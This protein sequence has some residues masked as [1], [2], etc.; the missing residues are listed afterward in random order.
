MSQFSDYGLHPKTVSAIEKLGF[1]TPS[2]IQEQAIPLIQSGQDISGLAQTGTG[3]TAAYLIPT[4]QR[5]YKTRETEGH[6]EQSADVKPFE[7]WTARNQVLI[8]VPTRELVEQVAQNLRELAPENDFS[9]AAIYGGVAYDGQKKSLKDGADFVIATPGRL[10]D[11]YKDKFF[12]PTQVRSVI[13]DEADRM[14]DMGFKDDMKFLL[15]RIPRDRQFLVL[16]ATLNFDVLTVAYEYGSD[17]VEIEIDKSLPKTEQVKDE[18]LHVG[19]N[20]KPQFLLSVLKSQ[21]YEQAIVFSNFVRMVPR[22]EK[23]LRENGLKA[24]GISSALSQS[25]RM[26]V[27]KNFKEGEVHILVATDVAARGLDIENV[28]LVVNYELPDDSENYVHRIGRTG[29]AGREGVAISTVSERDV[30][31]LNRLESFLGDKLKIGWLE[32]ED[33][34]KK[35]TRFPYTYDPQSSLRDVRSPRGG[36]RS[37]KSGGGYKG[38]KDNRDGRKDGRSGDGY[39]GRDDKKFSPKKDYKKKD[40]KKKDY[41]NEPMV[42]PSVSKKAKPNKKRKPSKRYANYK[43]VSRGSGKTGLLSKI[44]SIFSK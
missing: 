33:L 18:I 38:N 16:S 6:E 37:S 23:F 12:D 14:F 39:K 36:D 42:T 4:I 27:M 20:E 7:N 35:F 24:A 13:F 15:D 21:E 5:L 25:Q 26:S 10:I 8:L 44:F 29:R 9:Y 40:Y 3:K 34:I 30:A 32:N 11:L 31:A 2:K 41:N 1:T 28:D 43:T 22:I 19:H 17:P